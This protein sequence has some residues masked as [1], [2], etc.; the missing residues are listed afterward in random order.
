MLNEVSAPTKLNKKTSKVEEN[1]KRFELAWHSSHR[2]RDKHNRPHVTR[3]GLIDYLAGP[4]VGMSESY[5]KRQLQP[6]ANTFIGILIDAGYIAPFERGWSAIHDSC[7]M[8]FGEN[9]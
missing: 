3:S 7:I 5:A 8:D 9:G 6:T 1:R 4:H 2:E